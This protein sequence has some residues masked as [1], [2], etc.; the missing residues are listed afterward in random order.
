MSNHTID[1][2]IASNIPTNS[3]SPQKSTNK[4]THTLIPKSTHTSAHS[5]STHTLTHKSTHTSTYTE[6]IKHFPHRT[7]C[8]LLFWILK[9]YHRTHLLISVRNIHVCCKFDSFNNLIIACIGIQCISV[10]MHSDIHTYTNSFI[11]PENVYSTPSSSLLRGS[12]KPTAA[13]KDRL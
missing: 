8:F 3:Q 5:S 12:S 9:V 11:H 13:I 7:P 2:H 1:S 10:Y 4:S 6:F